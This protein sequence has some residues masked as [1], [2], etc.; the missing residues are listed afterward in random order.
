MKKTI[1]IID[2]AE[3]QLKDEIL[4]KHI[5]YS[6]EDLYFDG[7]AYYDEQGNNDLLDILA[8]TNSSLTHLNDEV[9]IIEEDK[10][11]EKLERVNGSDLVDLQSNSSLVEQNKAVTNLIMYLNMNVVKINEIIDAIN[12]LK[13]SE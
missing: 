12:E 13:K 11:I 9:E 8:M 6:D 5:R 3:K 2:L 4:P 7:I 10:K 1:K